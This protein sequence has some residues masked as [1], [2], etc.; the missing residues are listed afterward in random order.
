MKIS[1]KRIFCVA[2]ALALVV[3]LGDDA[4]AEKASK[5][6]KTGKQ[7]EKREETREKMQEKITEKIIEK[8]ELDEKTGAEVAALLKAQRSEERL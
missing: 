8:L 1:V 4:W 5:G 2:A 7:S 6:A 3:T